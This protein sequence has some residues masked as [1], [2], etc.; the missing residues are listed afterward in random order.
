M[1]R[2]IAVIDSCVVYSSEKKVETDKLIPCSLNSLS[3]VRC[4]FFWHPIQTLSRYTYV[5]L[6]WFQERWTTKWIHTDR[7]TWLRCTWTRKRDPQKARTESMSIRLNWHFAP[8][9]YARP[10]T[11]PTA[12]VFEGKCAQRVYENLRCSNEP[13]IWDLLVIRCIE[14]KEPCGKCRIDNMYQIPMNTERS[15]SHA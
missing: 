14:E 7:S 5:Q 13:V 11:W 2:N 3:L 4:L 6:N 15:I 1:Q 8:I 12:F 10:S 9:V